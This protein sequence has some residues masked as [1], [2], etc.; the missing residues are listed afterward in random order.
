MTDARPESR[1]NMRA[2]PREPDS[3]AAAAA[4]A[5]E[6]LN[7][8]GGDLDEG[9]DD[10][11]VNPT[12]VPDGWCYEWKRRT[13]L[14]QP[15]PSYEVALARTGWQAVP[16]GRHPTYMPGDSKAKTIERKGMV[17]MER[18]AEITQR[19]REIDENRASNQVRQK[20]A[21]LNAAPDGQFGRDNKGAP[22]V[23]VSKSY[24]RGQMP[25]PE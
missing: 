3:R 16:A 1:S 23:K 9:T 22:L 4:R 18:P 5:A 12:D 6:I 25:I 24:E 19:V 13:T 21:Q 10:F 15:D 2:E 17:L 20:E 8:I 11:Y 14:N 7:G